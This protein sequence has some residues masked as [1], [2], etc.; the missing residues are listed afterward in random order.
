LPDDAIGA[1]VRYLR[2]T[3]GNGAFA[4]SE[5]PGSTT[6]KLKLF[7]HLPSSARAAAKPVPATPAVRP[8]PAEPPRVWSLL[9]PY[10]YSRDGR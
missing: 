1:T 7:G 4:N 10:G 5:F 2:Y 9:L 3:P 8:A 6:M